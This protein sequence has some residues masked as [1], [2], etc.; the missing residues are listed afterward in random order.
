MVIWLPSMSSSTSSK[1]DREFLT[2]K[3]MESLAEL[4]LASV[5]VTV[6]SYSPPGIG[7]PIP[8]LRVVWEIV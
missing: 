5:A 8:F 3:A 2:K 4:P 7:F 6:I 1:T